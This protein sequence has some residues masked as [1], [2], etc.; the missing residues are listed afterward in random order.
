M[1]R[2][3][4]NTPASKAKKTAAKKFGTI[5]IKTDRMDGVIKIVNYREYKGYE[6]VDITFDGKL[7]AKINSNK[8]WLDS[9]KV[10]GLGKR[11]SKVK[12]N[13]FIR[14]SCLFEVQCRMKYF[15]A[16]IRYYGDIKKLTWI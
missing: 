5:Q 16:D 9:Q 8:E 4:Q 7:C 13:R 11:I 2:Y 15:G 3:L 12:L 14:K 6:E 1:S 10:K